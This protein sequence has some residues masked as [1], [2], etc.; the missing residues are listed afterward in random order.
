MRRKEYFCN[1]KNFVLFVHCVGK[2]SALSLECFYLLP[3]VTF[4]SQER[5][6]MVCW[7][8]WGKQCPGIEN[9]FGFCQKGLKPEGI[10]WIIILKIQ[11]FVCGASIIA[12]QIYCSVRNHGPNIHASPHTHLF[13]RDLESFILFVGGW[14][15]TSALW[16]TH[17]KGGATI[18]SHL[19][20]SSAYRRF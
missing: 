18:R 16:K 5:F 2:A 9:P 4:A 7:R 11:G 13:N 12:F 19:T 20:S 3:T 8:K 1:L 15:C 17:H 10:K 14:I 6:G